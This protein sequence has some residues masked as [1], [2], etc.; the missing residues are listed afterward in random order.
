MHQLELYTRLI[1]TEKHQ[2]FL[3]GDAPY[4]DPSPVRRGHPSDTQSLTV[5]A[6]APSLSNILFTPL[7]LVANQFNGTK[8]SLLTVPSDFA[9]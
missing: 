7:P 4:T 9:L 6:R 1:F 3:W 8:V 5:F 2:L